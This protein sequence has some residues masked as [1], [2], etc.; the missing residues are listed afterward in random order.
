MTSSNSGSLNQNSH[1]PY[2]V[3]IKYYLRQIIRDL[4][5]NMLVPSE[6]ELAE[7]FGV[8]RG[9][10]KQAIMDLV[11]EGVLYRKQGKGTF[12][13]DFIP[14]QYNHLPSFTGDIRK[15]G[16]NAVSQPLQFSYSAPAPRARA[17]FALS[18]DEP[19]LKY[20]RL[21]LGDG[22]PIA[23]VTSF[24]NGRLFGGLQM[25][26]IG[27]SLYDSLIKKF[28]FAPTQAH[29]TYCLAEISPKTAHLLEQPEG[30]IVVYSERLALLSDGT[31]AEFVENY[32][33]ADRFKL[34]IDYKNQDNCLMASPSFQLTKMMPYEDKK[35]KT[36]EL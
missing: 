9:T 27:N 32:I 25:A 15:A 23:V 28:G 5:P 8:S 29:D 14:R 36:G 13:A 18:D 20:K 19:V 35:E 3:Q 31:P 34:E 11:Y 21:V 7:T 30:G 2:Y 26:D 17:F 22:S 24:L 6:K 4:G 16:H 1:L 33:R 12:T 10:A